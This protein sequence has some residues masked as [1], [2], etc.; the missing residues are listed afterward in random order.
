MKP[1]NQFIERLATA[2][3]IAQE[4][5]NLNSFLIA[6]RDGPRTKLRRSELRSILWRA[7]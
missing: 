3:S 1:K 5:T 7:E 6:A 2:E 4:I